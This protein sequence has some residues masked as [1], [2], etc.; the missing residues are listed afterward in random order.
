MTRGDHFGPVADAPDGEYAWPEREESKPQPEPPSLEPDISILRLNRR[1]PPRFPVEIFGP[2]SRWLLGTAE[3]AAAPVDY[4]GASLIAIASGL[5]GNARW[6]RAWPGWE[7]PPHLWFALVGDSGDGKTPASRALFGKVVAELERRMI[8]DFPDR[9]R[10]W[11][12]TAQVAKEKR[13]MWEDEVAKAVKDKEPIPSKPAEADPEPMPEQ[14]RLVLHDVTIEKV[15]VLLVGAAPKGLLMHRDELAGF[16]LGMGAYNPAARQFWLECFNGGP[17]RVDRKNS[18]PINVI[19][20]AVAWFGGIQPERLAQVM[21]EVDVGLL[22]RFLWCWPD[23]VPFHRPRAPSDV[24]FA[25]RSLERLRELDF[26]HNS[27]GTFAPH[28]VSL[29][30]KAAARLEA[31]SVAM[32]SRRN[33][34]VGLL[35][36]AFGKARGV[37]LRLSLVIEFLWWCERDGF[38]EPP[39]EISDAAVDAATAWVA[40]Y[41]MPMGARTFGDA[42]STRAE[43]NVMTLARYIV[44]ERPDAV[45]TRV[46][47]RQ[48]RL[49]GLRTADDIH[50]ACHALI[51]AGWLMP[52]AKP[53]GKER[54][55][56][57]YPINPALWS[58]LERACEG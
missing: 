9:L 22:A 43:R 46:M 39:T 7:E 14:P 18:A 37:A 30:E 52:G 24:E 33:L 36:S 54:N 17:Y 57:A 38:H 8:G 5:I 42:A 25:L 35:R 56:A 51:D 15:A 26:Q 10:E 27:D 19:R 21:K 49:D 48:V 44:Q 28:F 11:E 45:H 29:E 23:P 20:N 34:T 4:V 12:A 6:A 16:L 47:Q 55:R 41:A 31:F 58:A 2:W 1:S 3:A 32:Q 13:R 50:A 40:D 53:H